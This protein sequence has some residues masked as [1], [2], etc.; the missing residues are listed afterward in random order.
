MQVLAVVVLAIAS[1]CSDSVTDVDSSPKTGSH[2][3]VVVETVFEGLVGPTQFAVVDDSTFVVATIN[4]GENDRRGQVVRIDTES[5]DVE[6]LR[7]GLDKPTGLALLD[8]ELW[9][10]ERDT[11]SR[12]PLDG[13]P[14][15]VVEGLPNNGRSEGTL[16]VTPDG[17]ILFDTSGSK[18]GSDVVEGSGRLFTVDPA[19]QPGTPT[20]IASGFK[21]AYAHVYDGAGVLWSTEMSDGA[22]DGEPAADELVAVLT[23]ADHGWPW[24]VGNNRPVAE[25]GGDADRCASVPP[26]EAVFAPGATPTSVAVSPF[27]PDTLLVAL[28]NEGRIVAIDTTG[29]DPA[30]FDDVVT[31]LARPQHL[32]ASGDAVYVTEFGEGRL[33]RLTGAEAGGG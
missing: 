29:D 13:E 15:V 6:I 9:V 24:C 18:R 28:W 1:A 17:L 8:G 23:G 32:V 22:F 4:G 31:G 27:A 26:S 16:T 19:E 3:E 21:H 10:M 25:F 20:E 5:G 2:P 11:L 30:A 33:L 12:G 7:D 14:T